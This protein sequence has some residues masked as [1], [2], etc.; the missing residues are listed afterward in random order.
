MAGAG[1]A[2]KARGEC[3]SGMRRGV[4]A[5]PA[6]SRVGR[7]RRSR[8]TDGPRRPRPW[9][10]RTDGMLSGRTVVPSA[11]AVRPRRLVVARAAVGVPALRGRGRRIGARS[12]AA[13]AGMADGG[14]AGVRGSWAGRCPAAVRV[15]GI[16]RARSGAGIGRARAV[17]VEGVGRAFARP[18]CRLRR[19]RPSSA[20]AAHRPPARRPALGDRSRVARL[21]RAAPGCRPALG[22]SLLARSARVSAIGTDVSAISSSGVPASGAGS[23]SATTAAERV[24]AMSAEVGPSGSATAATTVPATTSPAAASPATPVPSA[25]LPSQRRPLSRS[26][27]QPRSRHPPRRRAVPAAAVAV[28]AG[29]RGAVEATADRRPPSPAPA[30]GAAGDPAPAED[31]IP[32]DPAPANDEPAGTRTG[33]PPAPRTTNS[34]P[35]RPIRRARPTVT[36][37]CMTD[38][39]I[40]AN[41]TTG[42]P[43]ALQR[44]RDSLRRRPRRR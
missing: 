10:R 36:A 19:D 25:S 18:E 44:R 32:A 27:W 31:P 5:R 35:P 17:G 39:G 3:R 43:A 26:R 22:V 1:A 7:P 29:A 30:S 38:D 20:P 4:D 16:A 34:R 11:G 41:A 15:A 24:S 21:A 6:G 37:P 14:V 13:R 23:A 42:A 28:P 33:E 9:A 40:A 12:L 2:G 8:P